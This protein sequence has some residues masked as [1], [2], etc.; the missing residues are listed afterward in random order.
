[1][2]ENLAG[3]V[4]RKVGRVHQAAHKSQVVG[5]QVAAVVQNKNVAAIE[6][7]PFFIVGRVEVERGLGGNKQQGRI[8]DLAF[9]LDADDV[10]G[11]V[12]ILEVVFIEL[13]IFIKGYI[14]FS[15]SQIGV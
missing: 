6:L 15:R 7:N 4:E 3:D 8:G 5:Q 9:Y 1:M 10:G 13:E 12:P 14:F 11:F 2:L